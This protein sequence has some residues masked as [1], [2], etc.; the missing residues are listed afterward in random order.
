MFVSWTQPTASLE[1]A[2]V[3]EVETNLVMASN[4]FSVDNENWYCP[5]IY[6]HVF[7]DHIDRTGHNIQKQHD[8]LV[9]DALR[10]VL[11]LILRSSVEK[12]NVRRHVRHCRLKSNHGR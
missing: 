2:W 9:N 1:C 6:S 8:N 5:L 3:I 12:N 7:L 10:I 11:K 4:G